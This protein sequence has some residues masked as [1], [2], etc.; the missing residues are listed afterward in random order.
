MTAAAKARPTIKAADCIKTSRE[1]KVPCP[2]AR[3][4]RLKMPRIDSR[5]GEIITKRLQWLRIC[6]K[7]FI[8]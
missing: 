3:L 5:I 1:G 2:D 6:K 4:I 8:D 7:L